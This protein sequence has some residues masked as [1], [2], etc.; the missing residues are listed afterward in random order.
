MVPVLLSLPLLL[1]PAVLQETGSY[2]LIF[3]Y[4]GLSRPSKGLLRFQATAFL[5]DQ[6]FFHYNSNSGKAEPVEPWSHVE[7]MEDWEKESQLQRAREEIFLV[8]L[9]D[10]MDYYEDSTGTSDISSPY[11]D[12]LERESDSTRPKWRAEFSS[13]EKNS[14]SFNKTGSHTFQGMFGCEI[15]N[16]RSS[17]AVW[18]YAY[19]GE[20]F[21][22]FNKE[23]P[24]WIPLDPAAA[25]TKLKWEAEKV[26]VQRAKAYL[27]EECPTMLKKY[28]TYS[29]SHLDR[30]DPPTVKITSRVAPG[31]NRIFRC[32]AYD[33]Y[34]QRISLH[35][36]QASKKLASEPERGVFPNGNGTYLSWM[37]VEV[38]PQNRDPFVCH[39][40]HKGLSQ[41]LS[42]QWDEK[43]KV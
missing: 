12:P 7:G 28:L 31:R 43:S 41:S 40:E 13:G 37:E 10:I 30:T 36:N 39:I 19:D 32:L 2:S 34:P 9:K 11:P 3:L 14:H 20:D 16:N 25:N 22:E 18:R 21:I 5:N 24:A 26:Y 17:G 8:T 38:P 42:V 29:R 6:A 15:T 33:F 23:I 4:T 27:E 1:G 35:W